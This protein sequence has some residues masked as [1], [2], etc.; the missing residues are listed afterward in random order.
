MLQ[1]SLTPRT[2]SPLDQTTND[3]PFAQYARRSSQREIQTAC[4]K[5]AVTTTI[6][7]PSLTDQTTR[8]PV[9]GPVSPGAS[10]QDGPNLE[11]GALHLGFSEQMSQVASTAASSARLA[12]IL[13]SDKA[14]RTG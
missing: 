14:L 5:R 9:D 10:G 12:S 7:H 11:T 2:F 13:K 8:L 3:L 1:P 6:D 4:G